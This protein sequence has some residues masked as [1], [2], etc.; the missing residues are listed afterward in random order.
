MRV[1]LQTAAA[2]A[3][4]AAAFERAGGAAHVTG[5]TLELVHPSGES[6]RADRCE[7][8]FFVRAWATGA[9]RS[10]QRRQTPVEILG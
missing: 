1:R 9:E 4:L 5:D 6:P 10:A 2:A 3:S 7:L 8:E